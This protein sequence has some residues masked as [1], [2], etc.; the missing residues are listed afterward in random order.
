MLYKKSLII[1]VDENV[2][3]IIVRNYLLLPIDI[4]LNSFLQ[5]HKYTI[6]LYRLLL[7]IRERH[8]DQVVWV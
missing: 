8:S 1:W 5:S 3:L 4:N 7:L 2:S 6:L